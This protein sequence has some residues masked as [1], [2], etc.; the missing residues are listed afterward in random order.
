MPKQQ[1]ERIKL[2]S[3]FLD[4]TQVVNFEKLN[5]IDD[6]IRL[7]VSSFNFLTDVDA[8]LIS[9]LFQIDSIGQLNS[10]DPSQ[11]FST[12]YEDKKNKKKIEHL[13]QT[14]LEIE[15]KLM[16]AVTI[17]NIIHKIK[18]ESLSYLKK[19]Q[20]VIVMGLGNAGKTTILKKFGGQ[21]GIKDLA[22][23]KPTKGAE[24]QEIV[25]S[26]LILIIWDFGGQEEYRE[27]YLQEPHRYFLKIDL[28]IYVIDLQA[29]T[30]YIESIEYF[31]KILEILEKLEENP[32]ILIF[33]HKYD[34]DLKDNPDILLNVE[35]V[36]SLIKQAFTDKKK[37]DYEIYLSSIYSIL[38]REPKFSRYLKETMV[39]T[40]TLSDH[41]LEGMSS[42]L[43]S[44]LNGIIRLSETVMHQ[45]TEIERRLIYLE[46]TN[47]DSNK[48]QSPIHPS[49]FS[50][51]NQLNPPP[52]SKSSRSGARRGSEKARGA[53]LKELKELIEKRSR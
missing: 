50:S 24:R 3:K 33:L 39:K 49:K 53:V 32:H 18:E 20:K 27:M 17:S 9:E 10:L 46:N 22:R 51:L 34:P 8:S 25:T 14:D 21:I 28:V 11:P 38:A 7:P 29:P 35:Y 1:N 4:K 47:R 31:K 23:L 37:F 26:D 48:L 44:T 36:K 15:N 12:L 5:S 16:K 43:E 6:I 52:R 45:F 42:V 41:K 40:A 13:L 2:I 30:D 19:E